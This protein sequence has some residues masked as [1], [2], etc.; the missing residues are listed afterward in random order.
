[1]K[2]TLAPPSALGSAQMRPPCASTIARLTDRPTPVPLGFVV[3]ESENMRPVSTWPSPTPLSPTSTRTPSGSSDDR[4]HTRGA[5]RDS[6]ASMAFAMRFRSTCWSSTRSPCMAG[7]FLANVVTT[8]TPLSINRRAARI[9]VSSITRLMSI[10]AAS[11]RAIAIELP[12][13]LRDLSRPLAG[14]EHVL[15]TGADLLEIR[16]RTEQRVQGSFGIQ[17]DGRDRLKNLVRKRGRE[18]AH[19][20]EAGDSIELRLG[21][22]HLLVAFAQLAFER[23]GAEQ[24]PAQPH[25]DHDE[26][27][28]RNE[29]NEIRTSETRRAQHELHRA[30]QGDKG[31]RREDGAHEQRLGAAP[32]T[33]R[34]DRCIHEVHEEQHHARFPTSIHGF[35]W[36]TGTEIDSPRIRTV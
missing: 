34:R 19:C 7:R 24:V 9:R 5:G 33:P 26:E 32:P 22:A 1:M 16:R 25:G 10:G 20:R 17:T 31:R 18:L 3:Y 14:L 6:V 35:L 30:D 27:P 2:H 28:K 13:S 12:I 4:I 23:R 11:H 8:V 36:P 21:D 15:Q 29:A